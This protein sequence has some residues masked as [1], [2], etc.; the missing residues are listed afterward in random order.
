[1]GRILRSIEKTPQTETH[2]MQDKDSTKVIFRGM[3]MVDNHLSKNPTITGVWFTKKYMLWMLEIAK[4]QS[5][6][7]ARGKSRTVVFYKFRGKVFVWVGIPKK[8][9]VKQGIESLKKMGFRVRVIDG[10]FFVSK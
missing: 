5:N 6:Q 2:K 4:K 7:N 1:M 10:E 8:R 9:Y 3:I